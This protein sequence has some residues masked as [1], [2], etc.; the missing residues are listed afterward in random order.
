MLGVVN[1]YFSIPHHLAVNQQIF[2]LFLFT[3]PSSITHIS[4]VWHE[5]LCCSVVN[6]Y[7]VLCVF[8]G[9]AQGSCKKKKKCVPDNFWAGTWPGD[10]L[11][12]TSQNKTE[13]YWYIILLREFAKHAFTCLTFTDAIAALYLPPPILSPSTN[14]SAPLPALSGLFTGGVAQA[15]SAHWPATAPA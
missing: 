8:R 13:L 6:I 10:G 1:S 7:V 14:I 11:Q 15:S 5:R 2:V 12:S 3:E 9:G 4:L